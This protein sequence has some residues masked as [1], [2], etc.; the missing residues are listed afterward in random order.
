M[1][2]S[3][4]T[5]TFKLGTNLDTAQVLTQN[6]VA[7]AQPRL[8]DA[9]QRLGV[10]VKKASP[11]IMM[12]ISLSSP[13]SSRDQLYISNYATL[14]VKDVLARIDGVGDVNVVG[15]R[16]FAMR[17]WLDPERVA[18]RNLTAGEVVSA[19]RAQNVQVSAGVLNQPPVPAPG[20]FQLN[21][22]TLGRLATPEQFKDIVIKSD[23]A[24]RTTRVR[25]VARVELGAQDYGSSGYLDGKSAVTLIIYQQPGSNAL[26]TADRVKA[27][28]ADLARDFP[29]GLRYDIPFNPTDFI[30]QS[31]HEVL[32]TI[33]E[34]VAL[35]VVVVILF[36]QT[37]RASVI[38]IVAIPISLVG[39]LCRPGRGR[40]FTEHAQPV[41][42]GPGGR[43]RRR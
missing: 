2:A 38:P 7:I 13:D 20:A 5:V 33:W 31:V 39:N 19:L 6:R 36:L 23:A 12:L 1:A 8:P 9:V 25:D 32:T 41:R 26:A 18:A 14:Q 15:A 11:D 28:M 4:L 21:V 34:A 29:G 40:L 10:T 43:H 22:L 17:V 35:V 3:R 30:A 27:A 42:A 24:G 37:W 16:D